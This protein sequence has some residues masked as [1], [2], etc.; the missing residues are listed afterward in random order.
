MN[1]AMPAPAVGARCPAY[2]GGNSIWWPVGWGALPQPL[3]LNQGI[4][5]NWCPDHW[6]PSKNLPSG[7]QRAREISAN[8]IETVR[9]D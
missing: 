8:V 1:G 4:K 6:A 9:H 3:N 2:R 7:A 5:A